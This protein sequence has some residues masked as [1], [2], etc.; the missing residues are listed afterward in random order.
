[1]GT[2]LNAWHRQLLR[3][4]HNL[5]RLFQSSQTEGQWHPL[6]LMRAHSIL[7]YLAHTCR[8]CNCT[9]AHKCVCRLAYLII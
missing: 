3:R 1:M 7:L 9:R 4:M 5:L 8:Y 6:A 2:I